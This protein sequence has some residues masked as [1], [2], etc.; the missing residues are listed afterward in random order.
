MYVVSSS[1]LVGPVTI[2]FRDD[3]RSDRILR[4]G[5]GLEHLVD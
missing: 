4:G 3:R 5:K 2:S 1:I